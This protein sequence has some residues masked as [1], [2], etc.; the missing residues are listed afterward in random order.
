M[1]CHRHYNAS[2]PRTPS[3]SALPPPSLFAAPEYNAGTDVVV[4]GVEIGTTTTLVLVM[5][6]GGTTVD[7]YGVLVVCAGCMGVGGTERVRVHGQSVTVI[8]LELDTVHVLLDHTHVVGVGHTV[9]KAVTTVVVTAGA[10][11]EVEDP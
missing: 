1:A 5:Y 6:E 3:T 4:E 11:D 2:T 9:V 10:G 7:E 8:V